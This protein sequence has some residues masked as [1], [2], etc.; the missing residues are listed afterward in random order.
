MLAAL[1]DSFALS[2]GD[3][4]QRQ[5]RRD[6]D[7][8]ILRMLRF[9]MRWRKYI[10]GGLVAGALL[11]IV[12]TLLMTPQYASTV[13]LQ[14]SRD[15][16]RVTTID[17]VQRETNTFDQEFY[18]T[19][20][21]LLQSTSLAERVA[22]D[23]KLVDDEAFFRQAGE[24]DLFEAG[25]QPVSHPARRAKRITLAGQILLRQIGVA[26]VRGSSLVDVTATTSDPVQ[27]Q[28]IADAWAKAFVE[29]TFERRFEAS[30]YARRFL[31]E[32]IEALRLA[33]EDSERKAVGYASSQG[34]INLPQAGG[35]SSEDSLPGGGRSL[36]TDELGATSAALAAATAERVEAQSRLV[37]L[38]S[39]DSTSEA[40][41]DSALADMRRQ[42]ATIAADYAKATAQYGPEYP[43]VRALAGQLARIDGAIAAEVSRVSDTLKHSFGAAVQREQMLRARIGA[44]KSDL[45][46]LRSRSIQ[47][48]IYLRDAETNRELYNSLLQRYKEIGVAGSVE[49]NNIAVINAPK[50]ADEPSSPRLLV[51]LLL[52]ML[53]GG[54]AGVLV[55][56]A[57]NQIDE[58]IK[59]PQEAREKLGLPVLG[60]VPKVAEGAPLSSLDDPRSPLSEAYGSVQ[61]SLDLATAH[62]M[63]RSLAITSSRAREGKS[64]SAIAL[65]RLL[66]RGGDKV[67]L[68][69]ADMRSPS[70]HSAFELINEFG[71]SNLLAGAG[72]VDAALQESGIAGLFVIAAGP[73]PPN[74]VELL[75]GDGLR[76][77]I[78]RL[79]ERF[80]HIVVDSPPVLGLAD[81][82]LVGS[83][84]EGVVFVVEA[85]AVQAG[86][87]RASIDR[88]ADA[89]VNLI[90]VLLAKFDPRREPFGSGYGYGYGY[91]YGDA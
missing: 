4:R 87:A 53:A 7:P 39:A 14:I 17:G 33:L 23:L 3:T 43:L 75:T 25:N 69:D 83:A 68:L 45:N 90:G 80:D 31:Q 78:D 20:F 60:C 26:P 18:Q 55:A 5:P 19:Q 56:S 48:S 1:P 21:G 47:Y 2:S 64:T 58:T 13:R 51:N 28:K 24:D 40:L 6:A 32:R 11:G 29:T 79:L 36:V 54:L 57:L 8:A 37:A 85:E 63:P 89:R 70:A 67:V 35:E 52:S 88:L 71:L 9:A 41:D 82:Q 50:V 49:S 81:A 15:S 76:R 73:Q 46:D 77:L 91:G 84:V 38:R 61:A 86:A 44:L 34:I 12:L 59:G 10:I 27:S 22:L 42:Q 30:S 72:D 65:A 62:G 74:P 16:A 66:A